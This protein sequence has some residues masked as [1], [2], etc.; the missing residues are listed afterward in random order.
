[1]KQKFKDILAGAANTAAKVL[2]LTAK[3]PLG[4]AKLLTK[5]ADKIVATAEKLSNNS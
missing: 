5:L 1:M 4:L 2:V 3:A